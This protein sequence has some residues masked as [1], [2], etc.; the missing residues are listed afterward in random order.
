ME[1]PTRRFWAADVARMP[2]S[3]PGSRNGHWVDTCPV[4]GSTQFNTIIEGCELCAASRIA[5]EDAAP[6]RIDE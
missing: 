1:L 4:H 5:K 3:P 2:A 6:R